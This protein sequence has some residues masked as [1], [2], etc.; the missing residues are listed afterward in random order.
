MSAASNT[1]RHNILSYTIIPR[2]HRII[3]QR[4]I[5]SCSDILKVSKMAARFTPSL[6]LHPTILD[7]IQQAHAPFS[8]QG[9]RPQISAPLTPSSSLFLCLCRPRGLRQVPDAA[10]RRDRTSRDARGQ[11]A[12]ARHP[13]SLAPPPDHTWGG[14]APALRSCLPGSP[15]SQRLR[16]FHRCLRPTEWICRPGARLPPAALLRARAV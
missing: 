1:V 2:R 8:S 9:F 12:V 14:A 16:L 13:C 5:E 15:P 10:A 11:A 7:R 3:H 6:M 4:D